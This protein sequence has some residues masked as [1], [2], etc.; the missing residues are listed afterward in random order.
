M[1]GEQDSQGVLNV[2]IRT[3]VALLQ[4]RI[5]ALVC[6]S[7]GMSR[8][9]AVAAAALSIAFGGSPEERLLQVVAGQPHDVSPGLWE[10]VC[11]ACADVETI[12]LSTNPEFLAIIERSRQRLAAEGG[13]SLEE[14]RKKLPVTQDDGNV[15]P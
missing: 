5:P 11:R 2:A 6:C 7:A 13:I 9:P 8:S 14:M 12:S 3:L 1:D 4:Q 15:V 10:A